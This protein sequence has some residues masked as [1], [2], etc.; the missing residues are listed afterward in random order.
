MPTAIDDPYGPRRIKR[1][2]NTI[3]HYYLAAFGF[4]VVLNAAT[5]FV[6]ARDIPGAESQVFLVVMVVIA[7]SAIGHDAGLCTHCGAATP[8][9][10][11]AVA[12]RYARRLRLAHW[13]FEGNERPVLAPVYGMVVLMLLLSA[14]FAALHIPPAPLCLAFP[15]V[16][17]P[18]AIAQRTHRILKPWCPQ[19]RWGDGGDEE[20]SPAVPTPSLGRIPA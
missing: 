15:A 17:F 6:P 10:G 8:L 16:V 19:C 2:V 18:V 20:P 11:N 1:L 7:V 3:G 12:Q 5:A 4:M 9:D 14:A 13:W